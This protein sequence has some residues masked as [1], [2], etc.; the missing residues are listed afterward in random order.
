MSVLFS[1]SWSGRFV[2]TGVAKF[3]PLPSGVDRMEVTNE[4]VS[5]AA[6]GGGGAKFEWQR[7]DA[8]G[9]GTLYTKEATIGALVP[10][11]IAA[12]SG[13][14][15]L[16]TTIQTIGVL[17]NGSTAISAVSTGT[18]PRVTVGSTTGMATGDIVRLYNIAGAG[19]LNGYDFS[20]TVI[21]GTTFDL[22]NAATLAVAGTTGSFRVIS[23]P[24][25]YPIEREITKIQKSSVGTVPAGQTRITIGVAYTYTVGQKVR[26]IV[27]STVFAMTEMNGLEG[28]IVAVGIADA[29]GSTSTIDIDIDSAN[30]TTFTFPVAGGP[31]FSPAQVVPMGENTAQAITSGTNVIGDSTINTGQIGMLL[32]AGAASPAGVADDVITWIAFKSFNQ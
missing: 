9:R 2:S 13:F 26:I 24:Y 22:T 27:P 11:Q 23:A 29:G 7:G 6:G 14:Y 18:P 17:N 4:T 21:N 1:G 16:D 5:Y 19:Q 20:I 10:S 25:F 28:T 8:T 12:A 31:S 30:F 3:I 15:L 32:K